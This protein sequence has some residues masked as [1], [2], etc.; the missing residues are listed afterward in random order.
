ML[1]DLALRPLSREHQH[2]LALCVRLRRRLQRGAIDT[3]ELERMRADV[4]HFYESE[5]G[6]HFDAEERVLFPAAERHSELRPVTGRLRAEHVR[7]RQHAAEIGVAGAERLAELA[8][9]LSTHIRLEENDLF[10]RMQAVMSP[11]ELQA[12]AGP[13]EAALATTGAHCELRKK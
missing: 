10:E 5:G 13:L 9:L 4:R 3:A 8:E 11:E 12:L 2:G 7:I 1:R 6:A